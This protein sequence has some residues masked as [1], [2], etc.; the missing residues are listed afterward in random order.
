MGANQ[1]SRYIAVVRPRFDLLTW[2]ILHPRHTRFEIHLDD[3]RI[4]IHIQ[5]LAKSDLGIPCLGLNRRSTRSERRHIEKHNDT[6]TQRQA[7]QSK[8]IRGQTT[9]LKDEFRCLSP[10]CSACLCVSVSLCFC[11]HHPTCKPR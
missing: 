6:E 8:M 5:S 9:K 3:V 11:H 7:E 2:G 1:R 10:D 4:W